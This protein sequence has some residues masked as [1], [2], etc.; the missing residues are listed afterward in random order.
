MKTLSSALQTEVDSQYGLEPIYK[1]VLNWET[2]GEVHYSTKNVEVSPIGTTTLSKIDSLNYSRKS[3]SVGSINIINVSIQSLPDDV[4]R[5]HTQSIKGRV[6]KIYMN[7][8]G[9]TNSDWSLIYEGDVEDIKWLENSGI[10]DISIIS[11]IREDEKILFQPNLGEVPIDDEDVLV[12]GYENQIWPKAFGNVVHEKALRITEIKTSR[13]TS[14]IKISLDPTPTD[15][16]DQDGNVI[17]SETFLNIYKKPDKDDPDIYKSGT[18]QLRLGNSFVVE[19]S[20][21]AGDHTQFNISNNNPQVYNNLGIATRIVD[22]EFEFDPTV[23]WLSDSTSRIEGLT[24]TATG[25]GTAYF[26]KCVKQVG[27]RCH[28]ANPWLDTDGDDK[29]LTNSHLIQDVRNFAD[30]QPVKSED[31]D[32]FYSDVWSGNFTEGTEVKWVEQPLQYYIANGLESDS[33]VSVYAKRKVNRTATEEFVPVPSSYYTVNLANNLVSGQTIT[34]VT[35][36]FPLES[37]GEGWSSDIYVS[38]K[39]S[40]PVQHDGKRGNSARTIQYLIDT[41]AVDKTSNS[42]QFD[43]V[44]ELVK[45]YP[46]NFMLRQNKPINGILDEIAFQS[47]CAIRYFSNDIGI[48]YIGT[49]NGTPFTLDKDKIEAESILV[50]MSNFNDLKTRISASW[51]QDGSGIDD[52]KNI[53]IENNIDIYGTAERQIDFYIYNIESLVNKSSQF[54]L[55]RMSRI[56]RQTK[57]SCFLYGTAVE[58]FDLINVDVSGLNDEIYSPLIDSNDSSILS[59]SQSETQIDIDIEHPTN[60][61]GDHLPALYWGDDA[62]D[63]YPP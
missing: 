47:R 23:I 24:C 16:T 1:L 54:W 43:S 32:V 59:V 19:G 11:K 31:L 18:L 57:L 42:T 14:P 17:A 9:G 34:T 30:P 2:D 41:Y 8:S 5:F 63:T 3:K 53:E 13:L 62:G 55:N 6:A 56:W 26:N 7:A 28:F 39:S 45:N 48:K 15:E 51:K 50:K 35:F 25:V 22:S 36:D 60:D 37:R 29:L 4:N 44:A 12:D 10:I 49:K 61:S 46:A 40:Q 52:P 21:D 58:P 27:R 20:F 38:L 33:V